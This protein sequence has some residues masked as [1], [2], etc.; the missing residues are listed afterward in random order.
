[1]KMFLRLALLCLVFIPLYAS[2]QD[3]DQIIP[4]SPEAS[5]LGQFGN[6][7][8]SLYTGTPNISIP[9][10][11]LAGRESSVPVSLSYGG[12]G[13]IK[14]EEMATW[15]GL[16]WNLQ[17][18]GV[19]T[20]TV[21]GHPDEGEGS[22]DG[23]TNLF[24]SYPG[25]MKY[26]QGYTA[27]GGYQAGEYM[28]MLSYQDQ[29]INGEI[30]TQPDMLFYNFNGY[31]GKLM[32]DPV[33]GEAYS[34][35]HRPWQITP[36][37]GPY[38][39]L[40]TGTGS[41]R[42]ITEDGSLYV[43]NNKEIT[44][45]NDSE[46]GASEHVSAWYLSYME[47][48]NKVD[49]VD[50]SYVQVNDVTVETNYNRQEQDEWV[51]S[52]DYRC[53]SGKASSASF[54]STQTFDQQLLTGISNNYGQSV[55]FF[56]AGERRDHPDGYR[57]HTI[58]ILDQGQEIKKFTLEQSYFG[59]TEESHTDLTDDTRFSVRMRLDRLVETGLRSGAS[60][61]LPS[62]EFVYD[63]R[64]MPARNSASMDYWGYA[65]GSSNTT[66]L[67]KVN[68]L[69][70]VYEKNLPGGDRN[71]SENFMQAGVLKKV[72]YP[73]GGYT[74]YE[75]QGHRVN[76][77]L[78]EAELYEQ[79]SYS[80]KVAGGIAASQALCFY[81]ESGSSCGDDGFRGIPEI[82]QSTF[83]LPEPTTVRVQ[84]LHYSTALE[85]ADPDTYY[86]QDVAALSMADELAFVGF[87]PMGQN[88][89]EENFQTWFPV[90]T[91]TDSTFHARQGANTPA[92]NYEIYL[93]AGF[94]QM[95]AAST[96][97]TASLSMTV[98]WVENI[99]L[100]HT[101]SN[102]LVGGLRIKEIRDYPSDPNASPLVRAY[103]YY[104][105]DY[106]Q[107]A[108]HAMDSTDTLPDPVLALQS[109]VSFD[110][111]DPEE[112]LLTEPY[113]SSGRL[114][115]MPD[116]FEERGYEYFFPTNSFGA[117]V[118]NSTNTTTEVV[119][120]SLNINDGDTTKIAN[121][122]SKVSA[123]INQDVSAEPQTDYG[124]TSLI[125]RASSA[126]ELGRTQGSHVGYSKVV[127]YQK[128]GEDKPLGYT[129]Y[130]YH[131]N[132]TATSRSFPY[133]PASNHDDYNGL[134]LRQRAYDSAGHKVSEVVNEY[135]FPTVGSP[136][137][138][139]VLPI[140][141]RDHA[142]SVNFHQVDGLR[143]GV[144]QANY[145][146][147]C[148][149][150]DTLQ[151]GTITEE[152]N[153]IHPNDATLWECALNNLLNL[154]DYPYCVY[155]DFEPAAHLGPGQQ[156]VAS[157]YNLA[158]DF[159]LKEYHLAEGGWQEFPVGLNATADAMDSIKVY[160][161]DAE[162]TYSYI[163][164]VTGETVWTT[165]TRPFY[166]T[167]KRLRAPQDLA[168]DCD[169]HPQ[170]DKVQVG[171]YGLYSRW[172]FQKSSRQRSYAPG[173]TTHYT[174]TV[175]EFYYDNPEHAQQTGVLSVKSS[176][177]A[178][179]QQVVYPHDYETGYADYI[180][181]MQSRHMLGIPIRQQT[182]QFSVIDTTLLSSS[183]T[184][185]RTHEG[186]L[187]TDS[188]KVLELEKPLVAAFDPAAPVPAAVEQGSYSLEKHYDRYDAYGNVEEVVYKDGIPMSYFYGYDSL[189]PVAEII[190]ARVEE[191]A[192]TSFES[193]DDGRGWWFTESQ[194]LYYDDGYDST[195]KTEAELFSVALSGDY[196]YDLF[197]GGS[198]TSDTLAGGKEYVLSFWQKDGMATLSTSA[199]LLDSTSRT[200]ILGWTLREYRLSSAGDWHVQLSGN[201]Y[202]D[203][204]RLFPQEAQMTSYTYKIGTGLSTA[205]DVDN[206]VTHY[207]Y[208]ALGRLL[209]IR[210][211][212]GNIVAT[213]DYH[214]GDRPI[215]LKPF[216][217]STHYPVQG[218]TVTVDATGVLA[219]KPELA[220][221]AQYV[222]DFGDG[223]AADTTSS[224]LH[225]HVYDSLG[226]FTLTLMVM[227]E[228]YS[229]PL[230]STREL[231]VVDSI[232][233]TLARER[234]FLQ[235]VFADSLWSSRIE[236]TPQ[237]GSGQYVYDWKVRDLK[238]E[239]PAW[240]DA[241]GSN[242]LTVPDTTCLFEVQSLVYDARNPG[243]RDSA[244]TYLKLYP[245]FSAQYL[246]YVFTPDSISTEVIPDCGATSVSWYR[247]A[248]GDST[249]T[250][251]N[252]GWAYQG[253]T[254]CYDIE[255][256]VDITDPF[257]T[258]TFIDTVYA[259]FPIITDDYQATFTADGGATFTSSKPDSAFVLPSGRD[260][261]FSLQASGGCSPL[262]YQW[263]T[264]ENGTPFSLNH[265]DSTIT[266]PLC[267][268][269]QVRVIVAD[270]VK[271]DTTDWYVTVTDPMRLDWV[272][273]PAFAERQD[274][275]S[276]EATVL[277]G[278]GP[279][280]WAWYS[281]SDTLSTWNSIGTNS[282]SYWQIADCDDIYYKA[283]VTDANGASDSLLHAVTI[284]ANP[285]LALSMSP[286][287]AQTMSPQESRTF[288]ATRQNVCA[289][290]SVSWYKVALDGTI[291]DLNA[292]GTN[293]TYTAGCEPESFSL[294]AIVQDAH[295]TDS[296]EVAVT[297]TAPA[298]ITA[299]WA[300]AYPTSL[301]V[302]ENYTYTVT[303]SGGCGTL[304]YRFEKYTYID[305]GALFETVQ[306]G[307][308]NTITLSSDYDYRLR[309]Y[310][311]DSSTAAANAW[312]YPVN[313]VII[314]LEQV[315][316]SSPDGGNTWQ[317]T[318]PLGGR[319]DREYEW[320][321]DL[322]NDGTANWQLMGST[323]S[324]TMRP[325]TSG[326]SFTLKAT[327][328]D[329]QAPPQTVEASTDVY[330]PLSFAISGPAAIAKG[331]DQA[332]HLNA[333][334][335]GK[336][337]YT[338]AWQINSGAA[339][340]TLDSATITGVCAGQ[341]L[342]LTVTDALGDS[343]TESLF[344]G[345]S[346]ND[347]LSVSI[348][349][350]DSISIPAGGSQTFNA[351]VA[352]NCGGLQVRWYQVAL[353]GTVTD[354]NTTGATYTHT[355]AC[356]PGAYSLRAVASDNYGSDSTTIAIT[357][358]APAD[359]SASWAMAY[360]TTL[361]VGQS[362]TF[363]VNAGGGCGALTYRFEKYTF[364][365][366]QD[367]FTTVQEGSSNSIS[368]SSNYDY[369]LRCY[370]YDGSTASA[371]QWVY[372]ANDIIITL[373]SV[374]IS[375]PDGGLSYAVTPPLGGRCDRFY[376]W[377]Y[378]DL[379]SAA[380]NW[381]STGTNS[382]TVMRPMGTAESFSLRL[383][384]S[385]GHGTPQTV[386]D[387][388]DEVEP[389]SFGITGDASISKGETKTYS[390]DNLAGGKAPYTYE[391]KQGATVL[392]SS[393]SLSYTA[394][395]ADVTLSCTVTDALGSTHTEQ[396]ALSIAGNADLS[397]AIATTTALGTT[398]DGVYTRS[399]VTG[400]CGTFGFAWYK[401]EPG[402]SDVSLGTG[403]SVT[404]PA[405]CSL[406]TFTLVLVIT[407]TKGSYETIQTI[408]ATDDAP[409]ITA[410]FD[411]YS[412]PVTSGSSQT[413]SLSASGGC[414]ALSYLWYRENKATGG[415]SNLGTTTVPT[416]SIT[417]PCY[418]FRIKV[419]ISDAYG[420]STEIIGNA[421]QVTGS[422]AP[423]VTISR[424]PSGPYVGTSS[425]TWTASASGG[426]G[427]ASD[428][429]YA[430]EM[431][432]G[433][434]DALLA[435][436]SGSSF[437]RTLDA[438][439]TIDLTVTDLDGN[440]TLVEDGAV[441]EPEPPETGQ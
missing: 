362:A 117:F 104:E 30:E 306:E 62:Y 80:V 11:E 261:T 25:Y 195:L 20:R 384:V 360:P 70:G 191:V 292:N 275:I 429:T 169:F 260:V 439:V 13:G 29:I 135:R 401:R 437:S 152:V 223:T 181:E 270:D 394:T 304:F 77:Y 6:T 273:A 164:P 10:W 356:E 85:D 287:T 385:D 265:T 130:E 56:A 216:G 160:V 240:V 271:S 188:V 269:A 340:S 246:R 137:S 440:Q 88:P 155:G 332:Y 93:K 247:R 110:L 284:T 430:W 46:S 300:M 251:L 79:K 51:L 141:Y 373:Q 234:V 150:R 194:R 120:I 8:V 217:L 1:M 112:A 41:W 409:A 5:G 147:E 82:S 146:W 12:T 243:N 316:L 253:V 167:L 57:L 315:S 422:S 184:T 290:S 333:L 42:I 399:A 17:A 298:D 171:K 47:S 301:A 205:S 258:L 22:T 392:G 44:K 40:T 158:W 354:L 53:G 266:L 245:G 400:N 235:T 92:K 436:G 100:E 418:D 403:T 95:A 326:Q 90:A 103:E 218:Q 229:F 432:D 202:I 163:S 204:L 276:L 377:E 382:A 133:A 249:W 179:Y 408:T 277:N 386:S 415:W 125:R 324:S 149:E 323:T 224:I 417:A 73:T 278:C 219:A 414:G 151:D 129:V 65:N 395:C 145:H 431:R 279:Y 118:A 83:Y 299:S 154:G 438:S 203:E 369:R 427:S 370:V 222:W 177:E 297:V 159:E 134:L 424:S 351:Q 338:Y 144:L 106:E 32:I 322:L 24:E 182:W 330:E 267:S 97:A 293:Y 416:K 321:Y 303:A 132:T 361:A 168:Y 441:I 206:R 241:S 365:D 139:A 347:D 34:M 84:V 294:R 259:D 233:T 48:P 257:D 21:N 312:L 366:G 348:T 433:D 226:D 345:T 28:D 33:T 419:S 105:R 327:V 122:L 111:S 186:M 309:C 161:K 421:V 138:S 81:K 289:P 344:V 165:E 256:R 50:F 244:T 425:I 423:T 274:S 143:V 383:T 116:H 61:S 405:D 173:D 396:H 76:G 381:Q 213:Y 121:T 215:A 355:A 402:Q 380:V 166:M 231:T 376:V 389:I 78:P 426:C 239:N 428:Y 68:N 435:T 31:A 349:Q 286:A 341:N 2:A 27:T 178:I 214:Y 352:G 39:S 252:D 18:G 148:I 23:Y 156:E 364:I 397:V 38:D 127:E 55:Q 305:E 208:D 281:R 335:G 176:G 102:S 108:L 4:P 162:Y 342:S 317:V 346:G 343:H 67:P 295:S 172:V 391:W 131:N 250:Y 339:F 14:V 136:D 268:D 314:S 291:T 220:T 72:I 264:V 387:A 115:G 374:S 190:N 66:L 124:C 238:S 36:P 207:Y 43:F 328:K 311:Y 170:V 371:N 310:V 54:E 52:A 221:H 69:G 388:V 413:Y 37:Y 225:S 45:A 404:L 282:S 109:G 325:A 74:E 263:Y 209:D 101:R 283:V 58:S 320:R 113:P 210:D 60:E 296:A 313:D 331:A 200:G 248:L 49:R 228:S 107:V 232:G 237:G 183:F 153:Q 307:S 196:V 329:G 87:W 86:H 412:D 201:A 16:G 363:T 192:Y 157:S 175:T 7:P 410:S 334:L 350:G 140:P 280:T 185:Y 372:P 236:S 262:T 434:T 242:V 255:F 353:D 378:D 212:E 359:I 193:A 319:C 379:S 302:G 375:S 357:V 198:V 272:A 142:D 211:L 19:I 285:L 197:A 230:E 3:R 91:T 189:L 15:V 318:T 9:I 35:P 174:E 288:T 336:Q 119:G 390:A 187:K 411:S 26:Y 63:D 407:D 180:D 254:G 227:P 123:N 126:H 96:V 367:V 89:F 358:E 75:Y 94:Y 420:H 114:Y 59:T 199:T 71:P 398:T 406:Q 368:L 99:S 337:P 128:Q 393:A 308:S 64:P 98:S